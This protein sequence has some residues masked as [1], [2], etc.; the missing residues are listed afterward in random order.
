MKERPV[1]IPFETL[2]GAGSK[3]SRGSPRMALVNNRYKLPTD[4]DG[5]GGNDIFFDLTRDPSETTNIASQQPEI[6]KSMKVKLA[7]FRESC[8]RS[9]AGKDYAQ[10][11]ISLD[12]FATAVALTGVKVPTDHVLEGTNILPYLAGKR[13]STPH[14][15]LF[16]R[17]GGGAKYAVREDDW[18]LVG[19]ENGGTQLFNLVMDLGENRDLAAAQPEVLARL[20]RAYAD[21][22]RDNVAP[23]FES[24]QANRP[25]AAKKAR[26]K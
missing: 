26:G 3:A 4:M 7:E 25:K 17:A 2:G 23:L 5:M 18:K 8:K 21:W 1:P 19:G 13:T 14:D 11:V 16:W 10:P 22:N 12:V 24:P 15:R 9:L 20:G 6:V